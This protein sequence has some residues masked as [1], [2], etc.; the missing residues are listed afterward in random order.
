MY[1]TPFCESCCDD[2]FSDVSCGICP[3]TIDF[4]GILSTKCPTTVTG[5]ATEAAFCGETNGEAVKQEMELEPDRKTVLVMSGGFGVGPM[6]EILLALASCTEKLQVIAVCG[7]N[8]QLY[9]DLNCVRRRLS[10]PVKVIGFTDRV[11]ELMAASDLMISKAGGIS[12]TEALNS[13]TPMILFDSIPGQEFWNEELLLRRGAS[14]KASNYKEIAEMTDRALLSQ[15]V[16]ESLVESIKE[17]RSPSAAEKIA[18]TVLSELT[19]GS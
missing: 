3:A 19:E 18:R 14:L 13:L 15:D 16:Y 1:F 7:H 8:E 17:L 2:I 5:I 6:R 11:P 12:V 10:Y 4:C 9:R